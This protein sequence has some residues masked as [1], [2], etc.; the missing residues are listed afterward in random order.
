MLASEIRDMKTE[1]IQVE[2]EDAREELMRFR[3]Q[4]TTGE[5]SDHNQLKLVRKN[6]ARI[7]TILAERANEKDGE[8]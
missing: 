7:N 6:I 1:D 4:L 2:L 3:F 5:L 8:Q